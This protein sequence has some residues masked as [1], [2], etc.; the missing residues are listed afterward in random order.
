MQL[1]AIGTPTDKDYHASD[2][3]ASDVDLNKM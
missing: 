3:P 1:N 2:W